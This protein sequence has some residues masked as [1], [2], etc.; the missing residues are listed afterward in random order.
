M[1]RRVVISAVS[2]ISPIGRGYDEFAT[3]LKQGASGG[4]PVS[5]FD[6][7]TFPTRIAAE[8]AGFDPELPLRR[9]LESERGSYDA[10][11]SEDRK[12]ALGLA[13]AW[14]LVDQVGALKGDVALHLGTGLSS[15]SVRELEA[16]LVPFTGGD[17][18]FDDRAY[19]AQ[20]LAS[21]ST[22]PWRHL[23][24]E[25]NRLMMSALGV[26][27]P[28]SSSFAAC[29]ASTH[30]IGRAF[31]DVAAG[32]VDRAVAGGMDSMVHPFGMISFMRLGALSTANEDPRR[33]SR[34]FDRDRDGFLLGEGGVLLLLETQDAAAARGARPLV[35]VLG[36]GTSMD[37]HAVTAPHPEGRGAYLAMQRAV[38]DAGLSTADVGYV[39]AHGTGTPLNDGTESRAVR[40]LWADQGHAP[41]P[42]SSTKSMTGHLIAAAGALEAVACVAALDRG[43]LPPS[44]NIENLDPVCEVPIVDAATGPDADLRIAMTNSFGFGGQN[45]SLILR[46]WEK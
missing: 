29:A 40:D 16:D 5:L 32:R 42:M 18:S 31:R 27:G 12:T 30:A 10:E 19:G 4:G 39:N 35:E 33:A 26:S 9:L 1:S 36:Y 44:I 21:S 34:P 38:R 46:R 28:S 11:I 23:T 22:S 24:G 2:V 7:S 3:A 25:A 43:F 37:A 41:P 17:G 45:G 8:V 15:A 20:C 6:A 14:D 13:A